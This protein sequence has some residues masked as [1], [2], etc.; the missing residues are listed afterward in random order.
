MIELVWENKFNTI[1][2]SSGHNDAKYLGSAG[3]LPAL[4]TYVCRWNNTCHNYTNPNNG[5]NTLFV[6]LS[7]FELM[8]LLSFSIRRLW[9]QVVTFTN[10]LST[11]LNDDQIVG[12]LT[13]LLSQT[14]SLNNLTN[15]WNG[16]SSNEISKTFL[17]FFLSGTISTN[18]TTSDF[19]QTIPANTL[20][21]LFAQPV[22]LSN[23]HQPWFIN[24]TDSLSNIDVAAEIYLSMIRSNF[25]YV[26]HRVCLHE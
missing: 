12:N 17:F 4:Q 15:L 8:N 7:K 16:I 11:V 2:I 13:E 21:I 14:S 20:A 26:N 23:L 19:N 25:S 18:K 24:R 6:F 5:F 9:E 10:S 22:N 1:F 3:F